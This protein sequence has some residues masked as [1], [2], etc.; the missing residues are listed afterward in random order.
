MIAMTGGVPHML[1]VARILGVEGLVAKPF[2]PAL[3]LE[4]IREILARP[5]S[6]T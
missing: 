1:K 4:Q 3:L 5:R 6:A 2:E